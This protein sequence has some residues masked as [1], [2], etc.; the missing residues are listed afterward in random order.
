MYLLSGI[1][2]SSIF[3]FCDHINNNVKNDWGEIR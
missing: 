2:V 1:K 3:C